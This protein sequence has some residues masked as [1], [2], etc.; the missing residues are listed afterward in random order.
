MTAIEARKLSND[1]RLKQLQEEGV[2]HWM[3][4]LTENY[5]VAMGRVSS[6]ANKGHLHAIVDDLSFSHY[7]IDEF[8]KLGFGLEFVDYESNLD[9]KKLIKITW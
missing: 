8:E 4:G 7:D 3:E 1:F 6:M 5:L 9:G 2:S